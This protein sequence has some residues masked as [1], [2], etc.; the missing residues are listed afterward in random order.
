MDKPIIVIGSDHRG[1]HLKNELVIE[2]RARGY[3]VIDQG[4]NKFDPDDDYPIYAS[5]VVNQMKNIGSM[6]YGVL[7]CGSGQGMAMTAN[8]FKG[9]RA[10]VAWDKNQA[11][12]ARNDDDSNVLALP[13]DVYEKDVKGALSIV[14]TFV[15]VPFEAIPRRKRRIEKMDNL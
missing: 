14:E 15:S 12:I 13:A 11:I 5:R 1:F 7:L 4:D 9:I 10:V 2:L 6:S 8:R 3:E